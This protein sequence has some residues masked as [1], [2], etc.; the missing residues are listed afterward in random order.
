M[1]SLQSGNSLANVPGTI[2]LGREWFGN[3]FKLP[4][5]D[6]DSLVGRGAVDNHSAQC[7]NSLLLHHIVVDK[8]C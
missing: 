3:Y 7:T 1:D 5:N 6:L 4:E 8:I 2:G